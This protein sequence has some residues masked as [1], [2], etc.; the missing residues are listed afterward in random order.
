[1]ALVVEVLVVK[2]AAASCRLVK[3]KMEVYDWVARNC[4]TIRP[5]YALLICGELVRLVF[6]VLEQSMPFALLVL[7]LI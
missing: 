7:V 3:G 4:Y 2:A 5:L 1:M 6:L